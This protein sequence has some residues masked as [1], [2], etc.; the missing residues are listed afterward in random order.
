MSVESTDDRTRTRLLVFRVFAWVTGVWLLV[1]TVGMVLK[2]F[3]RD[4]TL[5]GMVGPIHGFLYMGYIVATLMLA[6]RVRWTPR[7]TVLVLLAGTVPAMS[8]V[9]ERKVTR[10]VQALLDPAR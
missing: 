6:D 4:P 8:F 9:A 7:K 3:F 10:E 5:V 2:Y 1:L